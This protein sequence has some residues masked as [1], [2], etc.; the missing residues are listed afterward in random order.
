VGS[1]PTLQLTPSKV[2]SALGNVKVTTAC[3]SVSLG[4]GGSGAL[5]RISKKVLSIGFAMQEVTNNGKQDSIQVANRQA[6]AGN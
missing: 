3:W 4:E 2:T 1:T 6:N 5:Y